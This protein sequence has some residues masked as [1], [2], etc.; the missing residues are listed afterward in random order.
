[1]A[2]EALE[3]EL[4]SW[5]TAHHGLR[6][7]SVNVGMSARES[8]TPALEAGVARMLMIGRYDGLRRRV[9][10]DD[11]AIVNRCRWKTESTTAS[12]MRIQ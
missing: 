6:G 1:M 10:H 4:M 12:P 9:R 2:G 5:S 8:R 3:A 11:T 7:G